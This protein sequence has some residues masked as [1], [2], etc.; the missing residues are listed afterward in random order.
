MANTKIILRLEQRRGSD[1][2]PKQLEIEEK[3]TKRLSENKAEVFRISERRL[4]KLLNK[5]ITNRQCH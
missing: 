3:F 2:N 4:G 5:K 1:P